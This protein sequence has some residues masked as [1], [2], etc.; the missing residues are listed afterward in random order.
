MSSR[1]ERIRELEEEIERLRQEVEKEKALNWYVEETPDKG[2]WWMAYGWLSLHTGIWGVEL[3]VPLSA[4]PKENEKKRTVLA[5]IA[6]YPRMVEV[7][8]K[9]AGEDR[10][11]EYLLYQIEDR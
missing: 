3:V 7:I 11:A 9:H 4:Y 8:Q 6:L 2:E 10:D 5:K 1:E